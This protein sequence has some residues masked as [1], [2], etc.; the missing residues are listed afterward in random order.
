MNTENVKINGIV[1]SLYHISYNGYDFVV[2]DKKLGDLI[3]WAIEHDKY[4]HRVVEIADD[5]IIRLDTL[6]NRIDMFL[7]EEFNNPT[8]ED[9]IN[10]VKEI[11]EEIIEIFD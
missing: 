10:N 9:V 1:Y 7:G 6:D 4:C 8:E 11:I 5:N 2:G 3:V